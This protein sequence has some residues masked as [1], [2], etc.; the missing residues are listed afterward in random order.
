MKKYKA[1]KDFAFSRAGEEF[2]IYCSGDGNITLY[3]D[4]IEFYYF[5]I[6]TDED[7]N[8]FLDELF[9]KVEE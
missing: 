3:K 9:E 2:D 8:N 6:G 1:K 4:G 5:F 7:I